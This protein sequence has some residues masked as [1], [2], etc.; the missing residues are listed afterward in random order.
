MNY[1]HKMATTSASKIQT[2]DD[3]LCA[4]LENWFFGLMPAEQEKVVANSGGGN[5]VQPP[6]PP[7][8]PPPTTKDAPQIE[9]LNEINGTETR[10]RVPSPLQKKRKFIATAKLDN[11]NT[12]KKKKTKDDVRT[13]L[14]KEVNC[15]VDSIMNKF[16]KSTARGIVAVV[17]ELQAYI[18]NNTK[19]GIIAPGDLFP[20]KQFTQTCF[21]SAR[22]YGNIFGRLARQIP[23]YLSFCTTNSSSLQCSRQESAEV[24]GACSNN[25]APSRVYASIQNINKDFYVRLTC[26][27]CAA[28]GIDSF[29][30]RKWPRTI[31]PELVESNKS[32]TTNL[33]DDTIMLVRNEWV[34][35]D[36]S[37]A[38][39][40]DHLSEIFT[41]G[42]PELIHAL[43]LFTPNTLHFA[44]SQNTT[45][46]V[47]K[48]IL[49][50]S[51][52][53][54]IRR[55]IM[56]SF[57]NALLAHKLPL[58]FLESSGFSSA[59]KNALAS[60]DFQTF[61][62]EVN[63]TKNIYYPEQLCFFDIDF[64]LL[65]N[66][67]SDFLNI[68]VYDC[69]SKN[70]LHFYYHTV[71]YLRTT[72]RTMQKTTNNNN[73]DNLF[74]NSFALVSE[75][76]SV[77]NRFGLVDFSLPKNHYILKTGEL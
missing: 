72:D 12:V 1:L 26:N 9:F 24:S 13:E 2:E 6:P 36:L 39:S 32:W 69:Y 7:P 8:P 52:N 54:N 57:C 18:L 67:S 21:N 70:K 16:F 77:R 63:A 27:S 33:D 62:N 75:P 76:R 59:A 11:T 34:Y 35:V 48:L 55:K 25:T 50:C 20:E 23:N 65:F 66:N 10:T 5:L 64:R 30:T 4:E 15:F 60:L 53:L 47:E 14:L 29:I 58:N 3:I 71:V 56:Q 19:N 31:I 51:T 46:I 44:L 43:F 41:C 22:K 49:K 73:Q 40:L 38:L 42:G 45:D 17:D 74:S 68:C 37:A 28:S 61:L